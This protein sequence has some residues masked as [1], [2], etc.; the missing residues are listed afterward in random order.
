MSYTHK[1]Y[2]DLRCTQLLGSVTLTGNI[3]WAPGSV[4]GWTN[5]TKVTTSYVGYT[6]TGSIAVD[7]N[8]AKAEFAQASK[9]IFG[10]SANFLYFGAGATIA[11]DGFPTA[12]RS[13]PSA[14]R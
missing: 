4:N 13:Q 14:S 10:T 9:T 7:E 1:I 12:F 6:V 2:A 5:V 11:A 8:E 3:Q